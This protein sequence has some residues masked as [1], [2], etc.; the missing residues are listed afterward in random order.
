MR[1][2][3]FDPEGLRSILVIRLYFLGDVLF[4]TPVLEALKGRYPGAS[5]TVLVKK[6][7]R[8]I[9]ASNPFVDEVLLYDEV[10][11]YHCPPWSTRLALLL[12][13]RRFD[14]AVDLTGDLRSSWLLFACEPGFR[15]GFNHVGLSFLLDRSIPY[16]ARGH[17][18]D[19]LLKAVEPVGAVSAGAAPTLCLTDDERRAGAE[20]VR[21][22]GV[23]EGQSYVVISPGSNRLARRWPAPRFGRL[24]SLVRERLA[25]TP[26]VTG[27]AD[28]AGL[29]DEVVEASAGAAVSL[30]GATGVRVFAAVAAGAR[31]FV[32]NDSGP[33]HIAASQGTPVVGLY[34]PTDPTNYAPRGGASRVLW[35]GYPCCPCDQRRCGRESDPCMAAISVDEAFEALASVLAETNAGSVQS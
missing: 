18:I 3:V 8:D 33:L 4:S 32:G 22:V 1:Q 28:D 2:R 15:V 30:A 11:R 5:L 10:E 12:R 25:A 34:G 29:A 6:R 26:I 27:A 13:R 24:S 20:A 7:A 35:A 21:G 17:V 31:A 23:R 19:H 16:R 9:L 14:L